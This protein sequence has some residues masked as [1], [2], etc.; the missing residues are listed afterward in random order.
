[1]ITCDVGVALFFKMYFVWN[2]CTEN[3]KECKIQRTHQQVLYF[4]LEYLLSHIVLLIL[5][6]LDL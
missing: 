1:V 6:L 3:S 2:I 5:N 4:K